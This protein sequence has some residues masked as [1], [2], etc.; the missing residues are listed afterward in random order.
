MLN[1]FKKN[2]G[3]RTSKVRKY[4]NNFK[5]DL[6]KNP[7]K[8]RTYTI[9]FIVLLIL[10]LVYANLGLFVAAT[11][12]GVPVTRLQLIK[13]LEKQGG[14]QVMESLITQSL[15]HQEAS[16]NNINI[17][18]DRINQEI[19][20]YDA[21]LKEQGMDLDSALTL[22]GQTRKDFEKDIKLR[23]IVNDL[24]GKDIKITDNEISNYYNENKDLFAQQTL[25]DVKADIQDQL[26]QQKLG[27]AYQKWIQDIKATAEINYLVNF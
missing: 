16:K 1:K 7:R 23:L 14:Q 3:K 24:I 13:E 2:L 15:I 17:S 22:Q 12:N 10:I 21:R 11:V 20:K 18:Q 19:D 9:G 8:K 27:E 6:N 25:D 5:K 26:F 4:F